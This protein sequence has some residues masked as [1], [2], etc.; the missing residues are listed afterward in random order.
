MLWVLTSLPLFT[1]GPAAVAAF[2]ALHYVDQAERIRS[3]RMYIKAFRA[4]FRRAVVLWVTLLLLGGV[5]IGCLW[6]AK[7]AGMG[8]IIW[9][10][11]A[12]LLVF[13]YASTAVYAYPV[14]IRSNGGAMEVIVFSLLAS[15]R[16]LPWT[17][18]SVLLAG[19]PF[20]LLYLDPYWIAL[21]SL[22]WLLYA[23]AF[24]AYIITRI[25]ERAFRKLYGLGDF[26]Y[27]LTDEIDEE[28]LLSGF[29][30]PRADEDRSVANEAGK[31]S[32][33]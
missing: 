1:A 4:H 17:A 30:I 8:G 19:I 26:L 15:L 28:T 20:I 32:A 22:L 24:I 18:L 2:E 16:N 5:L 12:F 11:L 6:L 9:N 33:K 29:E 7:R 21:T 3:A 14:M 13:L 23:F 31:G 10:A 25:L 27:P